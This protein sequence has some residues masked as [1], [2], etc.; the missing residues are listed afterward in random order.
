[1]KNQ[2]R[3]IAAVLVGA[4]AGAAIALLLAPERGE[5]LRDD[6]ADF[7]NGVAK[8]T[9]RRMIE[10]GEEIA[11][12][13]SGVY[14]KAKS[15]IRDAVKDAMDYKH[16]AAETAGVVAGELKRRAADKLQEAKGQIKHN[17]NEVNNTIQ[18]S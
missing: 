1:M 5:A 16:V 3:I 13:G 9:R 15:K 10:T 7:V 6:I 18:N 14:D 8:G 17:A 2:S 11:D 12:Y 4:A